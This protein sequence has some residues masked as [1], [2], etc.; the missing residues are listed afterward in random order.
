MLTSGELVRP[1]VGSSQSAGK[2]LHASAASRMVWAV[3]IVA[4]FSPDGLTIRD[5][6]DAPGLETTWS[7]REFRQV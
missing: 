4:V 7:R 1:A 2:L 5:R 3:E 6:R